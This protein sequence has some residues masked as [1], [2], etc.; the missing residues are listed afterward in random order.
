MSG[1]FTPARKSQTPTGDKNFWATSWECFNDAEA[2]Y[3]KPFFFDVCAEPLTSK[4]ERYY[5]LAEG[6]DALQLSWPSH[7]W[8]NPPFDRKLEFIR[9]AFAEARHGNPGMMLLPYEPATQWWQQALNAGVIIYEPA[10]RYNF[11][12][13]D[14]I[15]KKHGVNFPSAFVLFGSFFITPSLKIPFQKGYRR[16]DPEGLD[17]I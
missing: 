2:L 17:L 10:G 15:T 14:G 1:N 11:L 9:K 5:S 8:C 6:N 16:E 7:W 12:E 3:G 4:C 13:R